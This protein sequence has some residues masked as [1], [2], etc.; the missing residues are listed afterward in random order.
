MLI[1]DPRELGALIAR[2]IQASNADITKEEIKEIIAL[3]VRMYM[4]LYEKRLDIDVFVQ[5][6]MEKY[7]KT[8]KEPTPKTIKYI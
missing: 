3:Y 5:K 2:N 7:F 6:T 4:K 1:D 8:I